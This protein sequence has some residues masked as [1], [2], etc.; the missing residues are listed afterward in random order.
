MVQPVPSNDHQ[1]SSNPY[2]TLLN[3][4]DRNFLIHCAKKYRKMQENTDQK[5][6]RILTFY[7]QRP[8]HNIHWWL[9]EHSK[10]K[11]PQYFLDK[12][13]LI[14]D[15]VKKVWLTHL[16]NRLA[17]NTKLIVAASSNPL[18]SNQSKGNSRRW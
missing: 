16:M 17:C 8:K 1:N 7:T 13:W 15:A 14:E 18:V 12:S 6:L 2:A 5:K 3:C 4:E 9:L 11:Q 10:Q